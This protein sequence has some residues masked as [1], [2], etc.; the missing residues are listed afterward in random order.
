MIMS[1]V[2][3][4]LLRQNILSHKSFNF[5]PILNLIYPSRLIENVFFFQLNSHMTDND[6]YKEIQSSFKKLTVLKRHWHAYMMI[7][8]L[9][10]TLNLDSVSVEQRSIGSSHTWPIAL[11]QNNIFV[12]CAKGICIWSDSNDY[13]HVGFTI[14]MHGMQFHICPVYTT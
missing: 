10:I 11:N 8:W 4:P 14:R 7:Q 3:I 1:A 9:L 2:F 12:W 6:L 13:L 5:N